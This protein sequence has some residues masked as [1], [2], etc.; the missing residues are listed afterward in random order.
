[1]YVCLFCHFH[2]YLT[3]PL[4]HSLHLYI[5]VCLPLYLA[6]LR[7]GL[8]A[9]ACTS[10]LPR[11]FR[12]LEGLEA[13]LVGINEGAI[14]SEVAPFGGFKESGLGREGGHEGLD[15]FTETKYVNVNVN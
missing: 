5:T 7:L 8:A 4:H 10:S 14:S 12:M 15:C 11:T 2:S 6:F 3:V 9:Y 1:M 13:G